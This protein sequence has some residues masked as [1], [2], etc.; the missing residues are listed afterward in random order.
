MAAPLDIEWS[1]DCAILASSSAR[2][3]RKRIVTG[4]VSVAVLSRNTHR[5]ISLHRRAR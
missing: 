5:E 2:R 1:L 4:S 3:R